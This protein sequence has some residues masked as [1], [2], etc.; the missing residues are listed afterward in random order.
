MPRSK[1]PAVHHDEYNRVIGLVE[2]KTV[3]RFT[4]GCLDSSAFMI[5][6]A[7]DGK[8][9]LAGPIRFAWKQLVALSELPPLPKS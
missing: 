4:A 2:E 3:F 8:T 6:V 7:S 1:R 9:P 5:P